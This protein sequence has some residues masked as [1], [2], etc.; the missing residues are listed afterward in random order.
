MTPSYRSVAGTP[1]PPA[2]P[3]A[4]IQ[5]GLLASDLAYFEDHPGVSEFV[6]PVVAGEAMT[7]G[8]PQVA[9]E[10]SDVSFVLVRLMAGRMRTRIPL[11]AGHPELVG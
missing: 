9:H 5:Q 4:S 7:Y 2:E 3:E 1:V 11:R 8:K 6:R 10:W